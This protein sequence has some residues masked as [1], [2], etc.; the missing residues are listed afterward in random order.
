MSK[1]KKRKDS[2]KEK[3]L[4]LRALQTG[5]KTPEEIAAALDLSVDTVQRELCSRGYRGNSKRDKPVP[6]CWGKG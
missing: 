4:R 1:I 2:Y 5:G 6:H 3:M